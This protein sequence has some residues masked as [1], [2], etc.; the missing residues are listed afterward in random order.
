MHERVCSLIVSIEKLKP[1]LIQCRM[2]ECEVDL[3]KPPSSWAEK[4]NEDPHFFEMEI[5]LSTSELKVEKSLISSDWAEDW[6]P[7]A[8]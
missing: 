5:E 1:L 2:N 8:R 3:M 7:F 6:S 4:K